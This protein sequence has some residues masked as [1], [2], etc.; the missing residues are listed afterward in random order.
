VSSQAKEIWYP[1]SALKR[2]GVKVL[3]IWNGR[4]FDAAIA[5][6]PSGRL[7]WGTIIDSGEIK[8]LPPQREARQWGEQPDAW[9]PIGAWPDPLP[10][11]LNTPQPRLWSSRMKFALVDEASSADLAKEMEHDRE[12]A[13]AQRNARDPE[14]KSQWWKDPYAIKYQTA[15]E[16]G[17]AD[18]GGIMRNMA[19]GRL[20]RAVA[21]CGAGYGLSIESKTVGQVLADLATAA[22]EAFRQSDPTSDGAI[23]FKPL[24]QDHQDFTE[25]MRW[26]T[27][28]NPPSS[29]AKRREA[30]SFNRMQ[31]TLLFRAL[32]V[33]LNWREIGTRIKRSGERS[34]QLYSEAITM[35]TR[36]ANTPNQ[37]S[38]E[39]EQLRERN[40]AFKR[41][42]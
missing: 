23:R 13:R 26:F 41:A 4:E 32:P 2:P 10:E 11:P 7:Q 22:D 18:V 36:I 24:P 28:L 17:M 5:R 25:A 8:W 21:T 20:M 34:R 6:N 40:K 19:E 16:I 33:P 37:L 27:Q 1:L 9:R 15:G 38:N 30:W 39:M 31:K 42:G 35:A 14:T 29:W 12:S 3:V